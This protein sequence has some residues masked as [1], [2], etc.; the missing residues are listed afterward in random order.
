MARKWTY[1]ILRKVDIVGWPNHGNYEFSKFLGAYDFSWP[2]AETQKLSLIWTI[3]PIDLRQ[4]KFKIYFQVPQMCFLQNACL[5]LKFQ[6][7]AMN[8]CVGKFV[9]NL[10]P[11]KINL[12]KFKKQ[13]T[14]AF[15]HCMWCNFVGKMIDHEYDHLKMEVFT[16]KK[17]SFHKMIPITTLELT[18]MFPN[19]M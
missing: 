14:H 18:Q 12:K 10:I 16:T 8:G 11:I 13:K 19:F 15:G 1:L 3:S 5:N 6:T 2:S 17:R 7:P 4:K 9:P